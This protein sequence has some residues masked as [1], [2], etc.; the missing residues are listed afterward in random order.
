[1]RGFIDDQKPKDTHLVAPDCHTA[2]SVTILA[3]LVFSVIV[4]FVFYLA[5]KADWQHEAVRRGFA[6][7]DTETG[8]WAWDEYDSVELD[9]Y[10]LQEEHNE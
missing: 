4:L 1:M 8:E 3:M 9:Q 7:Y 5:V 2:V 6:H 10:P